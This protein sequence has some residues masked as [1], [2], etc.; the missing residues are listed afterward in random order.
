MSDNTKHWI[1]NWYW[2]GSAYC[3]AGYNGITYEVYQSN[4]GS[5]WFAVITFW[6]DESIVKQFPTAPDAQQWCQLQTS[7]NYDMWL[8]D[9]RDNEDDG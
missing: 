1:A 9:W 7:A 8:S 4:I 5:H 3:Y 2:P 6:D